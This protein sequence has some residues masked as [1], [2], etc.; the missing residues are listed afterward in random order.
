VFF[1]VAPERTSSNA[2]TLIVQ[3]AYFGRTEWSHGDL[4]RKPVGFR[5]IVSNTLSGRPLREPP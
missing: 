3:S 4:R 2:V 1:T 5:V